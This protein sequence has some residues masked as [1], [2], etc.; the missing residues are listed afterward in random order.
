MD[1]RTDMWLDAAE[2]ERLVVNGDR[3]FERDPDA[4]CAIRK[5]EPMAR[6]VARLGTGASQ[7]GLDV[8]AA[9][10]RNMAAM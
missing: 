10:F 6:G 7:P 1:D 5:V 4:C 3:L 9:G 8:D 2:F